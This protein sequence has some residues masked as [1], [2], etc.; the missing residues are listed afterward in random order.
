MADTNNRYDTLS[1]AQ[2]ELYDRGYTIGFNVMAENKIVDEEDKVYEPK[3]IEI[4]EFHRFEGMSN[5]ADMSIIYALKTSDGNKG[6]II[7]TYGAESSKALAD[8]L[9]ACER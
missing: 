1:Q 6:I 9:L 2:K 3:D 5:P 8:F 4:E 7:D